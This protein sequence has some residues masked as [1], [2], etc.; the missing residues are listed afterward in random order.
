MLMLESGTKGSHL[1]YRG[2][3][4]VRR[5]SMARLSSQTSCFR[6]AARRE[7]RAVPDHVSN[8]RCPSTCAGLLVRDILQLCSHQGRYVGDF[9]VLDKWQLALGTRLS[10]KYHIYMKRNEVA[11]AR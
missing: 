3:D 6:K 8:C 4:V 10:R 11:R 7:Y 5:G 1:L 9:E 2:E